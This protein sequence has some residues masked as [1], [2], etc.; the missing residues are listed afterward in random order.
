MHWWSLQWVEWSSDPTTNKQPNIDLVVWLGTGYVCLLCCSI[1]PTNQPA[2]LNVSQRTQQVGGRQNWQLKLSLHSFISYC[3]RNVV[4]HP[5]SDVILTF[6][7][8]CLYIKIYPI[9]SVTRSQNRLNTRSAC[10]LVVPYSEI[11]RNESP[12]SKSPEQLSWEVTAYVQ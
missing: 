7:S 5:V 1:Q 2:L 11:Y 4:Q 12:G 9:H 10:S 8:L 6:I 3:L